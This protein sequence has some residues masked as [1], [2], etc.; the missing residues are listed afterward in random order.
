MHLIRLYL[1]CLDILERQEIVTYREEEQA[2]LL[3][4]RQGAYQQPDGGFR[5]EFYEMVD[6]YDRRLAYAREHT[7]LPERPDM[8]E[9]EQL[10]MSINE[11]VLWD[12]Y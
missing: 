8:K 1:M 6:A 5:P 2:L 10:V 3:S 12:A 7:A 9:I 4:I 11:E